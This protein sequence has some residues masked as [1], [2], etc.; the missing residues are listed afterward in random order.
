MLLTM[1]AM[2]LLACLL[3]SFEV[4][5]IFFLGRRLADKK[6]ATWAAALAVVAPPALSRLSLAFMAAILAHG[7]DT[8]VLASLSARS[9]QKPIPPE[10]RRG[11]EGPLLWA[12]LFL[13]MALAVY[14]GSLI[15]FGLF[16]PLL[17]LLMIN[18]SELRRDGLVLA[19]GSAAAAILVI[20]LVYR[21][22]L[23]VFVSDMLPRFF[24]GEARGGEWSLAAVMTTLTHRTWIFYDGVYIPLIVGGLFL[25]VRRRPGAFPSRLLGAWALVYVL[26]I[27]LR[28]VAPDLFAKVK[29]LLWVAPLISLLGA[30]ALAWMRRA[31]PA[32]SWIAAFYY[33]ILAGYGLWFYAM[34]IV[35]TFELAH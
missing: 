16:M 14:P 15:N 28:T 18:K 21:E 19:A 32:G 20:A 2:K 10:A 25:W 17:A 34:A 4:L 31:L 3:S 30:E 6:T 8:L 7:L 9:P 12:L 13:V 35:Q 22:F 11:V 5:I 24:S 23:G 26:L 1:E 27:F 33:A 29:E